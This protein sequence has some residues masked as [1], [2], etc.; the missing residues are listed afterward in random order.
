MTIDPWDHRD[1]ADG[2]AVSTGPSVVPANANVDR[3]DDGRWLALREFAVAP[4][5]VVGR[6]AG[7]RWW[8]LRVL[9]ESVR[10]WPLA[11]P[12][13]AG[14]PGPRVAA[15]GSRLVSAA[16]YRSCGRFDSAGVGVGG[17]GWL[18]SAGWFF[19][20]GAAVR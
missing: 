2:A 17:V 15:G 3:L 6:S 1:A 14:R 19:L 4:V 16:V 8:I 10:G 18:G 11:D 9:A 13:G 20:V 7:G 12:A 5:A